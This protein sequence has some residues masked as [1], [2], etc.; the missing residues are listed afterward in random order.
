MS[1]DA[2]NLIESTLDYARMFFSKYGGRFVFHSFSYIKTN[3][4]ASREIGK[5]EG[6]KRGHYEMG[7]LAIILKDLGTADSEDTALDN[8]KII[9]AFIE[10]TAFTA[11]QVDELNYYIG[12]LRNGSSAR[13]GVEEVIR[14]GADICLALPDAVERLVLLRMERED[15]NG[16][17]Y[18]DVE[19]LELCSRYWMSR[20][21]QTGY[22]REKYGHRRLKNFQ[23]IGNKLE[24][25]RTEAAKAIREAKKV[26]PYVKLSNRETEDLFKIAFRNY[27]NL[28]SVADRKARILIQVNSILVSVVIAF[29]IRHIEKAPLYFIPTTIL[30][31]SALV[32]I[33]NAILASMPRR[34]SS[35][36]AALESTK[37]FFFG[38]FDRVDPDFRNTKWEDYESVVAKM[39]NG[40]KTKVFNEIIKESFQVRR[41]LARK[42]GH[43]AIAYMVFISGLGAGI[44]AFIIVALLMR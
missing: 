2:E 36:D 22:A 39:I 11:S 20:E 41:I 3:V 8:Q 31:I 16:K 26:E 6:Y 24:A 13:P 18:T 32:T 34:Q 29:T 40:D 15:V 25:A 44:A 14:D 23:E 1:K 27:V 7:V 12:F 5:A 4:D 19:W 38:S 30:L 17:T 33:F 43:L 35:E 9:Q 37:S 21:Y 42:F 10:Q 28:V